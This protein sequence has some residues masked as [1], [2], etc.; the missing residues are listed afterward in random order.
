MSVSCLCSVLSGGGL[1]DGLITNREVSTECGVSE[2]D[3]EACMRRPWPTRGC[4]AMDGGGGEENEANYVC[5]L[6]VRI[7]V[8]YTAL[9]YCF[10]DFWVVH[11]HIH[12][13]NKS[14]R[15]SRISDHS[16]L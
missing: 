8:V 2:C 15:V 11:I 7:S 5:L 16:L 4:C 1:P 9:Y 14:V 13:L 12:S 10:G 6:Y 3:R